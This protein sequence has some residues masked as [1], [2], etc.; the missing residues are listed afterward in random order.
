MINNFKNFRKDL[1]FL[2][3]LSLMIILSIES[4]LI[5]VPEIIKG[6]YVA[7]III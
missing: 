2:F 4:Y 3:T 7:G 5:D 6:G 1:Y